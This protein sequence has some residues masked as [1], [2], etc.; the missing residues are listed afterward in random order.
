MKNEARTPGVISGRVLL[1]AALVAVPNGCG[2]SFD[3]PPAPEVTEV[4]GSVTTDAGAS[5]SGARIRLMECGLAAQTDS[6][7]EFTISAV[8]NGTYTVRTDAGIEVGG[9]TS[10]WAIE[11]LEPFLGAV[12]DLDIVVKRT[13][14]IE[15]RLTVDDG[16]TALGAVVYLV[17]GDRIAPVADDGSYSLGP[18]PEGAWL[19]GAAK[20]GYQI[21]L[22]A[23]D[24]TTQVV[25]GQVTSFNLVLE[26]VAPGAVASISGIV[27][28]SN[29]G[30]EKGVEVALSDRFSSV[31]YRTFT[32]AQGR[33]ALGSIPAGLYELMA[34]HEGYRSVGLPNLQL[35]GGDSLVLSR[36]LVLPKGDRDDPLFP[37]DQ[38]PTGNPDDD[39]DGIDDRVDNCPVVPNPAQ[40]DLD[41]DGVGDAC[42][43][44]YE[45]PF[46][47]ADPDQDGVPANSDNCPNHANPDQ[48]N[49]DDD[50][51]GNACD[52]DDDNDGW[53]DGSDKC[54]T[55]PDPVNELALCDWPYDLLFAAQ[56]ADGDIRIMRLSSPD[57]E[58]VPIGRDDGDAWGPSVGPDGTV[59][60][61]Y[62]SGQV[63]FRI[64]WV[65]SAG[66]EGCFDNWTTGDVMHPAVCQ[67]VQLGVTRL[68][69][70]R[71]EDNHPNEV[72]NGWRLWGTQVTVEGGVPQANEGTM[73]DME[74][75]SLH[76]A[77]GRLHNYRY[78]ACMTGG[79]GLEMA[80]S[81]DF[82]E[83]VG[84][85][86]D[87]L[88]W[89]T[90]S[91]GVV[92]GAIRSFAPIGN[93][94]T[95]ERRPAAGDGE[96]YLDVSQGLQTNIVRNTA[97]GPPEDLV[98]DGNQNLSPAYAPIGTG[99]GVVAFSSDAGGSFDVYLL[100]L[101]SG[102]VVRLS[103]VA[104]WA[105]SP[106]WVR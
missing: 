7:G 51:L 59:Y 95:H 24:Q 17:G 101:S 37:W 97:D 96:W 71:Y 46:D 16:S 34:S 27:F 11:S 33:F 64:C 36:Q 81:V 72:D 100:S 76:Q 92:D 93:Q 105:G 56:E 89:N 6:L 102:T 86:D 26:P 10:E 106:A 84:A 82:R 90:Y 48:L 67:D 18:V 22:D 91:A 30:P 60:Y 98:A 83:V 13:G 70:E 80:Y 44:D 73:L 63:A 61:H 23:P 39:G 5:V 8:P 29:P 58:P 53:L 50:P 25:A 1:L 45:V 2:R 52:S 94:T 68:F 57:G 14:R 74:T 54:P 21:R 77:P 99:A 43:L 4:I 79:Q 31:R 38:D 12:R 47:P 20:A 65:T 3:A 35:R 15:G 55:L 69:Y 104:G 103:A 85:P 42:D 28:L 87:T 32:D 66:V 75:P 88:D 62:R 40:A 49:S 19:V 78:P 41:G 9:T